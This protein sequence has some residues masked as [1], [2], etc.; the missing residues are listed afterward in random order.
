M[1]QSGSV[2][3]QAIANPVLP[4]AF[5]AGREF[6]GTGTKESL[7]ALKMPAEQ[8]RKALVVIRR[9]FSASYEHDPV[10]DLSELHEAFCGLD[11]L[12]SKLNQALK[13]SILC[14]IMEESL[15]SFF[16]LDADSTFLIYIDHLCSKI[17][18]KNSYSGEIQKDA[19]FDAGRKYTAKAASENPLLSP[20]ELKLIW[21]EKAIAFECGFLVEGLLRYLAGPFM[22]RQELLIDALIRSE[23]AIFSSKEQARKA[24]L[25]MISQ[26]ALDA[27]LSDQKEQITALLKVISSYLRKRM[28]ISA[29]ADS[30][31]LLE[32][33]G[34]IY[35]LTPDE[36]YENDCLVW[37]QKSGIEASDL[38]PNHIEA[39]LLKE[40]LSNLNSFLELF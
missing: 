6:D 18:L 5:E 1:D 17:K 36:T 33:S 2:L 30:S 34:A 16:K 11:G 40:S 29:S 38:S 4:L 9:V 25:N 20:S 8:R 35:G 31:I 14:E 27:D 12:A 37:S 28:L 23:A 22:S 39:L 24:V 13:E 32:Q 3:I 7:F 19:G 26:C 10:Y 15:A 21:I